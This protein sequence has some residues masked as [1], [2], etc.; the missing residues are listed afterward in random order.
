MPTVKIFTAKYLDALKPMCKPC[1]RAL[2]E[3][4]KSERPGCEHPKDSIKD[5]YEVSDAT[6]L[7]AFVK[8]SGRIFLG[9]RYRIPQG[10]A[11]AGDHATLGLGRWPSPSALKRANSGLRRAQE[12]RANGIDPGAAKRAARV[13][14]RRTPR[15]LIV[16][17]L[18]AGGSRT[19]R[20]KGRVIKSFMTKKD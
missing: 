16:L 17:S 14:A 3:A 10:C 19:A 18:S 15:T 9:W 13:T 20:N 4:G 2:R 6:Q 11:G 7:R 12:D 5:V 8:S 1:E